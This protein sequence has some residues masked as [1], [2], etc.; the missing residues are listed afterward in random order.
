MQYFCVHRDASSYTCDAIV[1]ICCSIAELKTELTD[2][3]EVTVDTAEEDEA[4]TDAEDDTALVDTADATDDDEDTLSSELDVDVGRTATHTPEQSAPPF[5]GSQL[6]EGSSTHVMPSAQG[7]AAI[8]PHIA[9]PDE[10]DADSSEE[11]IL[12]TETSVTRI[13][14]PPASTVGCTEPRA[15][16]LFPMYVSRLRLASVDSSKI[17]CPSFKVSVWVP[18][19]KVETSSLSR[20][21]VKLTFCVGT[22]MDSDEDRDDA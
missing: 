5:V 12:S 3:D 14:V 17:I 4:T 19:I 18:C 6:S 21:P 13:N 7:I 9:A 16:T 22:G 2:D 20:V 1:E 10:D 8:P 11:S 15:S